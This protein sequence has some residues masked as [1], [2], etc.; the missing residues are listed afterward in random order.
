MSILWSTFGMSTPGQRA[1][2][3]I[4]GEEPPVVPP[5]TPD[6]PELLGGTRPPIAAGRI[7]VTAADGFDGYEIMGYQG[8][9]WG[10]SV[11]AKDLG[12]DCLMG[13]KN[14]TGGELQSYAELGDEARQR[15]MDKMFQAARRQGANAVINFRFEFSNQTPGNTGTVVAYGTAVIIQPIPDY[16][17]TGAAGAVLRDIAAA[18]E[19]RK[20]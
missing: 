2:F 9:C 6:R 10:V 20:P 1:R 17:P 7:L 15:A 14:L 18:L 3:E 19:A 5:R 13:C 16:I 8:I 4:S 12:Q 11:R